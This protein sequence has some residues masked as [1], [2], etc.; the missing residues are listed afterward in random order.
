MKPIA[1]VDQLVDAFGGT[2]RFAEWCDVG[3]STVSNWKAL[4][5]VPSGYHLRIYLEAQARGIVLSP[6]LFGFDD[7]PPAMGAARSNKRTSAAA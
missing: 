5:Y 4:G 6:R 2:S 3:P 7:W 1:K